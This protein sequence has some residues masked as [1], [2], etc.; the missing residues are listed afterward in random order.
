MKPSLAV[1]R[2]G[3]KQHCALAL[4]ETQDDGRD[5]AWWLPGEISRSFPDGLLGGL[6][7]KGWLNRGNGFLALL[8]SILVA[9]ASKQGMYVVL[10]NQ[11]SQARVA[12]CLLIQKKLCVLYRQEE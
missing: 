4:P 6:L 2:W 12:I 10:C 7:E 11:S 1:W 9:S 8:P 3:G 5:G